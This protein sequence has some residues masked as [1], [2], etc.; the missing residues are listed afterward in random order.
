MSRQCRGEAVASQ[1]Q[2]YHRWPL[3]PWPAER[4]S[5]DRL[6]FSS[7]FTACAQVSFAPPASVTVKFEATRSTY[8][9]PRDSRYPRSSGLA[10]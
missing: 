3:E 9:W 8:A 7:V 10:P 4:T 6:S 2:A 5:H 1:A